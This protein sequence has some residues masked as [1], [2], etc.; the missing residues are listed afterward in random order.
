MYTLLL[1]TAL[2]VAPIPSYPASA[3]PPARTLSGRVTG[4]TGA[5]PHPMNL[6]PTAA[7]S[8]AG[9]VVDS[10]GAPIRDARVTILEANRSTSTEPDGRYG[11][12]QLP[13]GTF[14]VSFRAIGFRPEVYRVTLGSERVTLDVTLKHTVVELTELQVTASPL[15]T[16]TLES[17]QPTAVLGGEDLNRAQAPSLGETLNSVPGVHSFSTGAGIGKPVIRGLTSNRVL[18]LD[19]G[20]RME[21]QQWGDEHSPNVETANAARV[22]VIRGPAS[23]LYGSDALGG[24]INVLQRDLP[25]AIGRQPIIRGST[26]AAYAS[27][28][29]EPDGALMVEGAS[30]GLAFR[31]EGSGRTAGDVRTPSYRLWNS[32]LRQGGGSGTLGYQGAWGNIRGT[33]SQRNEKLFLTDEDSTATPTQRMVTNRASVDLTLPFRTSRLEAKAGWERSRRREFEDSVT[34]DVALGLLAKT[35]TGSVQFHHPQLGKLSGIVGVS[36]LRTG[37]DKFGEETLIPNNRVWTVG[38]YAF[39]QAEVG[40]WHLS[41]G[42]RYDYRHLDVDQ[43]DELGVS[44]QTRT[45]NSVSGNFGVLYRLTE[46][47]AL[48]FNVGRGFRA[49]NSFELFANGVHEGTVA[50]EHGDPDLKNETS[51]NTDVA[52]RVQSPTVTL[53]I[54]GFANFIHNYIFS[55]PTG[56]TDPESGFEIFDFTQG[57]ARLLGF[58]GSVQY[59]PMPILHLQVG[60]DYTNG[61]NTSADEPLPT[62]PPFRATY[63]ARLEPTG[64]GVFQSPYLSFGGETN[65]KQSRLNPAEAEFFAEAFEGA[66]FQSVGYTL[67]NAG[68]GFT[69]NAGE[70]P[71][72]VD[73]SVHNLFNKDY[74]DFLS[75]IKT[76][77]P[78]PGM[79][80][81]FIARV[82]ANF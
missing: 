76:N 64:R 51:I 32:G 49:P 66:G 62:I 40:R 1:A 46:P 35:W 30:G 13:T 39:E 71:I 22:E 9:R 8:L 23:V 59:H 19:E 31:A 79:G 81:T 47:V 28:N 29:R 45:Y 67:A 34:S 72:Q 36:G 44:A 73:L 21:T 78:L 69:L 12:D 53:E 41:A 61:Q 58:E 75:R 60:A 42:A 25:D 43:D 10:A 55:I 80:R 54:G 7:A 48:V 4:T 38:T 20:Q 18:V 6:L 16:S 82:T 52:V 26:S 14:S 57:N 11:L 27:N 65:A 74:A 5:P 24:V 37:F 50:F 63:T 56:V 15:A 77:A 68:A 2:A 3:S 70:R 17:P 33:Y